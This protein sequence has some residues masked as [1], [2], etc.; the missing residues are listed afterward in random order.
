MAARLNPSNLVA[1]PDRV[2]FRDR[3]YAPPLR[4]LPPLWPPRNIIERNLEDYGQ[5]ILDQGKE[6]ACTGF[7]LAAVI[8]FIYWSSWRERGLAAPAKPKDLKA[9]ARPPLVSAN[10]LYHNARLYDEWEG[11]DYEGSS[12]RGAMK[13]WHKHGVC[14]RDLWKHGAKMQA[15]D[16]RHDAA[17]RPLGAY[18]RVDA[19]SIADIQAALF[20][21]RS[22]YCSATVHEGWRE[23]SDRSKVD[24]IKL[25]RIRF[26]REPIGGHAFALIGYTS[27]GFIVQNS[28]GLDWGTGGFALLSYEDW[29]KNGFDSWVAAVGAPMSVEA[30]TTSTRTSLVAQAGAMAK[31][32]S[33][34][35]GHDPGRSRQAVDGGAGLSPF[36]RARQ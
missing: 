9:E 20:E 1:R 32:A 5:Y 34:V 12:C 15:E 11:S 26:E 31:P 27:E 36:H 13:G 6:G 30:S 29:I 17:K 23:P 10:M 25:A 8:N 4:S 19:K 3:T 35:A 22:V 16:W 33:A 21:V 18:Y 28:W 24:G 7:G 2:D 14:E